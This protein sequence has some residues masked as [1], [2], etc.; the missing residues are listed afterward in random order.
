MSRTQFQPKLVGETVN[1]VFD[2]VVRL[3]IAETI[4]TATTVATVYS[5]VDTTP[6]NLVNGAASIS[7]TQVTQS[8]KGGVAG[9][10]YQVMCTIVTPSG[11]TFQLFGLLA[12]ESGAV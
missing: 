10:V 5:G 2:F 11:L 6:A 9:V 3:G 7:G 12:V 1:T 4:S 8:I